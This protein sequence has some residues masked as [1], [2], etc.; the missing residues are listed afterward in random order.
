[1]DDNVT[2]KK[3]IKKFPSVKNRKSKKKGHILEM[4]IKI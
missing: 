3:I 2:N 4:K 1:M